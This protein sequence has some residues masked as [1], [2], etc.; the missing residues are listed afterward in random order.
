[1]YFNGKQIF[2]KYLNCLLCLK[3]I[4]L[5]ICLTNRRKHQRILDCYDKFSIAHIINKYSIINNE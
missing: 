1:M 3:V 4:V 2:N 5:I